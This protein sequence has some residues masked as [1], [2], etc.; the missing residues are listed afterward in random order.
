MEQPQCLDNI[1]SPY[2]HLNIEITLTDIQRILLDYGL[3]AIVNNIELYKRAF[4]HKS[5]V[6]CS[7]YDNQQQKIT[8]LPQPED[9]PTTLKTKS[10]DRLEFLGDGVLECVTKYYLYKNFPKEDENFMTNKKIALVN[11]ES[12]GRIAIQMGLNKWVLISKHA[13]EKGT[14]NNLKKM[15]CLFEAFIGALF[16]DFNKIQIKDE[17]S[18]FEDVFTSGPG[19]Q[20]A[21]KFIETIFERYVDKVELII[22]DN[23]YKNILQTII[24]KEFKVV[25]KYVMMQSDTKDVYKMGIYLWVDPDMDNMIIQPHLALPF[26]NFGTL[27]NVSDY[28][29]NNGGV[30]L[31]FLGYGTHKNKTKAG[32]LASNF[33]INLIST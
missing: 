9:C 20:F 3:P 17:D 19:M 2:N 4:I 32:Q 23:N 22:N 12:I 14:R 16:L 5:Y 30:G 15:G 27:S 28:I 31:I 29:C 7:T 18:W 24:Q 10:N 33:V 26:E 25:P 11:N 8:L 1:Y 13:E 6:K 21:Q